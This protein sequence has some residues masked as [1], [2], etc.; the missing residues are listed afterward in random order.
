[1][2]SLLQ[3]VEVEGVQRSGRRTRRG[4]LS[5]SWRLPQ[6]GGAG[7]AFPPPAGATGMEIEVL[8]MELNMVM[9]KERNIREVGVRR[10]VHL[11]TLTVELGFSR[12]SRGRS[13]TQ[14]DDHA[15]TKETYGAPASSIR[16]GL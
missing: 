14:H 5:T 10:W 15:L 7:P 6:A 9:E 12:A 8:E 11:A 1:M 2:V 3:A 4:V 13:T 16:A